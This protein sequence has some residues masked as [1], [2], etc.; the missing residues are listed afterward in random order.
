MNV[1]ATQKIN[2]FFSKFKK[3]QYKKGEIILR[4]GDTPQGVCFI[5]KGYVKDYAISK[6]G[7][8]LSLIILKPKDFF[9]LI[10]AIN[11]TPREYYMEAITAVEAWRTSREK[12]LEFI[13]ANPDVLLELTGRILTRFGGILQRMEYMAFGNAHQKV[14]SILAILSERFGKKERKNI[15]IQVPL[16]HKDIAELLGLTRETASIEIKKLERKKI[17]AHRSRF[18]RVKDFKKLKEESLFNNS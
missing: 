10:W 9:P 6:D 7:E 17:I 1:S 2:D 16:T 14:A 4:A 8:E 3:Y 12:F 18:I 13:K 15:V 5:D 11:N